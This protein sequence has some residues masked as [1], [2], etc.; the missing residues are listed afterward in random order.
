MSELNV[1][2]A[3]KFATYLALPRTKGADQENYAASDYLP[4]SEKAKILLEQLAA[5]S[6]QQKTVNFYCRELEAL[7]RQD[8]GLGKTTKA[9][10]YASVD[11]DKAG[12]FY[13]AS[14]EKNKN[15]IK[16]FQSLP[17]N[18][19]LSA[20]HVLPTVIAFGEKHPAPSLDALSMLHAYATPKEEMANRNIQK[21]TPEL[22]VIYHVSTLDN[23]IP[24]TK[25]NDTPLVEAH[26]RQIKAL[27]ELSDT[28]GFSAFVSSLVNHLANDPKALPQHSASLHCLVTTGALSN[29]KVHAICQ[30]EMG[31]APLSDK[32]AL[33]FQSAVVALKQIDDFSAKRPELN[34]PAR[35]E[36]MAHNVIGKLRDG[37]AL[38]VLGN[39]ELA[40]DIP[41]PKTPPP[42]TPPPAPPE[43]PKQ[44]RSPGGGREL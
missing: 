11:A 14:L 1:T 36:V 41:P 29:E 9:N 4:I 39:A 32:D 15:M 19:R 43:T 40:R 13:L 27:Q 3:D 30:G 44:P 34:T 26:N 37:A 20:K 10:S 33:F 6:E 17:T 42:E 25:D 8:E 24:G 21:M 38:K 16:A 12:L 23:R 18:E 7:F 22:Q 28:K 2:E 31:R 35:R 5:T